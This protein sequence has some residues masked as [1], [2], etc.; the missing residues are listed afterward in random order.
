MLY[1]AVYSRDGFKLDF[2]IDP[3]Q[4]WMWIAITFALYVELWMYDGCAVINGGSGIPTPNPLRAESVPP[5]SAH[6]SDCM[7][8]GIIVDFDQKLP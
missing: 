4:P 1:I 3:S 2:E 5:K 7:F 6:W 8:N